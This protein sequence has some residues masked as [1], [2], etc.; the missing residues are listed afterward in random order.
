VSG[1]PDRGKREFL[2]LTGQQKTVM[3]GPWLPAMPRT[4]RIDMKEE[5]R[6][7][8]ACREALGT[9]LRE[10]REDFALEEKNDDL[11]WP[12]RPG[13]LDCHEG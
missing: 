9:N 13:E 8:S 4:D 3:R 7:N 1:A 6:K 5:R 10:R 12:Q 2:G 11:N